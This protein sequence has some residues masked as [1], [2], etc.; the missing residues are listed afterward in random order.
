MK[1]T[2]MASV[3]VL[4]AGSGKHLLADELPPTGTSS[5]IEIEEETQ[6]YNC[7]ITDLEHTA[8]WTWDPANADVLDSP[9][10]DMPQTLTGFDFVMSGAMAHAIPSGDSAQPECV[11]FFTLR[12]SVMPCHSPATL[13]VTPDPGTTRL[14]ASSGAWIYLP[15]VRK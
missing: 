15:S 8:I 1:R 14:R 12:N 4:V 5:E 2:G 7:A 10:H 3:A 9:A 13:S 11:G 6:S